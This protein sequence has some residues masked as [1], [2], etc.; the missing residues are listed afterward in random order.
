MDNSK[1]KVMAAGL[2]CAVAS[3][4]YVANVS[5]E[6][7][8]KH[9]MNE[10]I[11]EGARTPQPMAGGNINDAYSNGVMGVQSVQDTPFTVVSFTEKT[12]KAFSDP[13]Q[14]LTSVL[15]NNPSVRSTG[16]NFYDDFSIRGM[17][18]NGYQIYLN[19]IPGLFAQ[20]STPINYVGRVD[21]TAGPAMTT[22]VATSSESAGG[23]VNMVSAKAPENDLAKVGVTFSGRGAMTETIDMSH[24]FGDSKKWGIRINALN[25]SGETAIPD[26][27]KEQKNIFINVD[28]K[29]AKSNTNIL[30]GYV[31]DTV[32]NSLRWFTFDSNLGF[33]PKAPDIH[34]NYGFDAMKWQADK[35]I[36]TLNHEQKISEDWSAFV[37]AGYGRY[38]VYNN[39]NSDWRYTIHKDG[40]FDDFIALYPFKADNRSL[41]IGTKGKVQTGEVEHN[42]VLAADKFWGKSYNS[43]RYMLDEKIEGNLQDG[44]TSEPNSIPKFPGVSPFISSKSEYTSYKFVDTMKVGKFDIMAGLIKQKADITSYKRNADKTT[45][46]GKTITKSD[47]I[48]PLYAL[49]YKPNDNLSV[50]ASHSESFGKGSRVSGSKYVNDGDILNPTKTK[51]DEIGVK[52]VTNNLAISLAFF[53]T[54]KENTMDIPVAGKENLYQKTTD[55]EVDYKGFDLSVFGKL[56]EKWNVMGGVL[57]TKSET[58]KSTGG[59]YDG[60]RK[61][62]IPRWSGVTALEYSPDEDWSLIVRGIYSGSFTI[63][64]EMYKLPSYFTVDLGAKYRTQINNTPVTFNAMLYNAFDKAYWEPLAGGD[65]LILSNPRTFMLSAEF[66]L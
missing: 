55:G 32:K 34:K 6:A 15:A 37:N 56:S 21:V 3:V 22:N 2:L 61:N 5:A 59:K 8:M 7:A 62:G 44:I 11:I 60:I 27:E 46:I 58:D 12:I 47:D 64:N 29:D 14:P 17:N 13:T 1:K 40:S 16:T 35:W 42:L 31:D 54:V 26:E 57:Y 66:E 33:T 24:R 38:D 20:G 10:V 63:K 49:V 28:Y 43:V 41:Q 50:Y 51:Q 45:N 25:K 65:N 52:Y 30:M 4:S 48:S 36:M 23:F 39:S 19:G 9:D 53:D 18:L